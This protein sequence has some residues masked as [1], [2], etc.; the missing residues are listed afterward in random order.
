MQIAA[1]MPVYVSPYRSWY[2]RVKRRREAH[3]NLPDG[4]RVA[5]VKVGL[6]SDRGLILG[7]AEQN[8]EGVTP[9][10]MRV[11]LED[12]TSKPDTH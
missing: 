2:K 3:M 12:W 9:D 11:H 4:W 6:E 10:R 8:R 5:H 7:E 1:T